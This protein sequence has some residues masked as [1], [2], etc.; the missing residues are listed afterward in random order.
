VAALDIY[1]LPTLCTCHVL[2]GRV[3]LLYV[4]RKTC[5]KLLKLRGLFINESVS[6]RYVNDF[7]YLNAEKTLV[8]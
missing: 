2:S 1:G 5:I 6:V 7:C 3:C 8:Q 4:T